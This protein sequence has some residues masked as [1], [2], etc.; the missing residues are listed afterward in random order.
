MDRRSRIIV[1]SLVVF[2]LLLGSNL[3]LDWYTLG[4]AFP[5]ALLTWDRTT[6]VFYLLLM[7]VFAIFWGI[8]WENR[9]NTTQDY[10]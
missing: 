1:R 3:A 9:R 8:W 2:V 6:F 5:S 10:P 7:G 4:P